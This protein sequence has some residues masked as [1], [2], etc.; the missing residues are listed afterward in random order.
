MP[1]DFKFA[2]QGRGDSLQAE[3]IRTEGERNGNAGELFSHISVSSE[4]LGSLENY[5]DLIEN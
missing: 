1:W 2:P 4:V 5:V 3:G